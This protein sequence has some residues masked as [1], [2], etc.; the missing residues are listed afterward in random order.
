[1]FPNKET[2]TLMKNYDQAAA[3]FDVLFLE[4]AVQFL[5]SLDVKA[6][7]K[8]IYT[9]TKARF[10][11]DKELFKK[12]SDE[13]WEFRTLFNKTYYRLFAFWDKRQKQNTTVVIT[14]GFIK[15]SQ[16]TPRVEIEKANRLCNKYLN[17]KSNLP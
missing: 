3:K 14:N 6:R 17:Q 10:S 5:D 13:I 2:I 9:I 16:K 8:I 1:M 12:I 4:D 11:N 15:K 7:D